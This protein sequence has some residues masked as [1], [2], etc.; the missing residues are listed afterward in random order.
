MAK[1][2]L[3]I[4][5]GLRRRLGPQARDVVVDLIKEGSIG[6]EIGVWKGDFSARVLKR[7]KPSKLILVD[8]WFAFEQ[9]DVKGWHGN[10]AQVEMDAIYAKVAKRFAGAVSSGQV[11][12]QRTESLK[13]AASCED[14]SLDWI[15]LDAD[16]RY[17]GCRDDLAA[18][19]PKLKVGGLICGDDYGRK[20]WWDHGVTKAVSEFIRKADVSEVAIWRTQFVLRKES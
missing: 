2:P 16:H 3:R 7:A 12:I 11:E 1:S 19:L 6:V 8:P 10:A 4:A 13:A 5:R 20:G 14:A 15:Y 18:W 9:D 17:E